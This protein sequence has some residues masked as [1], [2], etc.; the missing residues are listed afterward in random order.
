[1]SRV[2]M[3]IHFQGTRVIPSLDPLGTRTFTGLPDRI[4]PMYGISPIGGWPL[5]HV[6]Y[7]EYYPHYSLGFGGIIE[8]TS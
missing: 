7:V 1:M 3:Q 8:L 4:D 5:A 6:R 2:S